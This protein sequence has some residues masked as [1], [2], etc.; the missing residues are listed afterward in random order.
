M[1]IHKYNHITG[2]Y[3]HIYISIHIYKYET[4]AVSYKK[5]FYNTK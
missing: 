5:S 4:A 2:K 3:I 1:I